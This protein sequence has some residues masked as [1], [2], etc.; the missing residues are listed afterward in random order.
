MKMRQYEQ[1]RAFCDAVVD[2]GGIETLNRVWSSPGML[3][4]LGELEA[5]HLWLERTSARAA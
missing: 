5:P 1:G 2:A 3:P 4:T